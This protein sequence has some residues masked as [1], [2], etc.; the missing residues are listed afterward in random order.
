MD[1]SV[2]DLDGHSPEIV[3]SFES[4]RMFPKARR[5]KGL[6]GT[7]SRFA[8]RKGTSNGRAVQPWEDRKFQRDLLPLFPVLSKALAVMV[9]DLS[10]H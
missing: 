9:T 7:R 4:S 2:I 6:K 8:S 10:R 5:L 1:V 3:A